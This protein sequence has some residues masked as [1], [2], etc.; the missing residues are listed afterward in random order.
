[1]YDHVRWITHTMQDIK[2]FK[3]PAK[4]AFATSQHNIAQHYYLATL[5]RRGVV[6]SNLRQQGGKT[7]LDNIAICCVKMLLSFGQ[8][9]NGEAKNHVL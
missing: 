8:S 6:V 1:M 7:A 3:A 5:L 2:E 9:L 4:P